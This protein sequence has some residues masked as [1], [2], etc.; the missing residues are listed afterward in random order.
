MTPKENERLTRVGTGTPMGTLLRRYWWP[1]WFSEQVTDK[2]VPVR[3]LGEHLVLYRDGGGETGL[4]D[5]RCPHRGASLELGRVEEDGLRCCYHGWKFDGAGRCLDMPMEPENTPL[6]NEVQHVAYPTREAAG[7]VFAYLGPAP[8]PVFPRYDMLFE[9]GYDRAVRANIDHCNWLQRAENSVD[10]LH[11]PVLHAAG[12]PELALKRADIEWTREWY[13]V[14]AAYTVEGDQGKVSHFLFPSSNRYFGARVGEGASQNM[15]MR[16]PVD[17]TTTMTFGIRA[18]RST[19]PESTLTTNGL[20]VKERGVYERVDDGWW[21][22]AS[23]EQ[24][25][26]AQESQG[27]IAD[28]TREVLGTS[29]RGVVM[30]RRMLEEALDAIEQ[31]DDPPGICRADNND[32]IIFDAQQVRDG[33]LIQA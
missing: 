1:V 10:Q 9:E 19:G 11:A 13:G 29:D 18:V 7:L 24:D 15:N 31:G 17:D 23:R 21:G 33:Q 26:A 28:R 25:R 4:L 3:I 5:Q 30:F 27:L 6:R 32:L 8:V 2:P 12:Y 14:R 20:T 22:I 16:V